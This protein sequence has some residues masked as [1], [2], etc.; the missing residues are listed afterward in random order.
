MKNCKGDIREFRP[1]IMV[2]VP[3][4][5]E[6]IRKGIVARVEQQGVIA[7]AAFRAALALKSWMCKYKIP[8][9][10]MF[11]NA[12]FGKVR[13][14]TGGRMRACANGAGPISQDTQ[15]FISMVVAPMISGY[16]MTESSGY[17]CA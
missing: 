9:S 14:A 3:T 1:T 11:D 2:G 4:V 8:G 15:R 17:V 13:D 10:D 16:G 12:I 7:R 5:W 6:G